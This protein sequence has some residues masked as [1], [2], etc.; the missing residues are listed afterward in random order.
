MPNTVP[1]LLMYNLENEKGVRLRMI[2]LKLKIRARSVK[3]EE[4]G[5]PV[6][7]LAGALPPTSSPATVES[8][9]GEMLVF[10]NFSEVLLNRYLAEL[11]AAR[12]PGVALKAVL[13]PTNM[14]WNSQMLHEELGKEHEAMHYRRPAHKPQ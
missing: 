4:Y 14:H 2:C 13:T 7:A 3:P 9:S 8:F 12:M 11:R 1:M 10:A 5:Q 6:G